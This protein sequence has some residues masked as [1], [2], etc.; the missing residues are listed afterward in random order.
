MVA[1]NSA[2]TASS[3]YSLAILANGFLFLSGQNPIALE[4]GNV[5]DGTE[6]QTHQFIKNMSV[7]LTSD[8]ISTIVNAIYAS[9]F[10]VNPRPFHVQVAK[11]P[12][13][14]L[15]EIEAIATSA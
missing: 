9:Y 2:P 4:T 12:K 7:I 3:P 10:P 15:I 6:A 13:D 8:D 1:T 5:S 11:L 14:V